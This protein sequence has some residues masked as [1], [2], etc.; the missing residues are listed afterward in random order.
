MTP[1]TTDPEKR[2]LAHRL[3]IPFGIVAMA[4]D[5]VYEGGRRVSGPF[6]FT[7]GISAFMVV[8]IAGFGEFPGYAIRIATG[9]L[10]DR[11]RQYRAFVI[12]GYL[13]IL[14]LCGFQLS[15][16]SGETGQGPGRC[17]APGKLRFVFRGDIR[18][19]T[20][21]YLCRISPRTI[22]R[23]NFCS[24]TT[25]SFFYILGILLQ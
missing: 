10:A 15:A 16:N 12:A 7:P 1:D 13:L 8:F 4:G 6:P 19:L 2:R 5:I 17:N 18:Q 11:S 3:I 24:G 9:Y 22:L 23:R 14:S 25:R 21:R 20:I